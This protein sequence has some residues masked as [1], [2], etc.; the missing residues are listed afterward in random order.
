MP[1]YLCELSYIICARRLQ[2]TESTESH[3]LSLFYTG[4]NMADDMAVTEIA[5]RFHI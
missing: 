4:L 1:Q 2:I 5:Q 3:H